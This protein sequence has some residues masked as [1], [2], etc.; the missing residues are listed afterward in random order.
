VVKLLLL[1]CE[2]KGEVVFA[3]GDRAVADHVDLAL[4]AAAMI[5]MRGLLLALLL[6]LP[7]CDALQLSP[8]MP[9]L[10]DI[11]NPVASTAQSLLAMRQA[12]TAHKR[13]F[14]PS[15]KFAVQ[16]GADHPELAPI[17]E[18]LDD[19]LAQLEAQ[20]HYDAELLNNKTAIHTAAASAT[21]QVNATLAV[22]QDE[23]TSAS[24][25]C[26]SKTETASNDKTSHEQ[27]VSHCDS[28]LSYIH[29]MKTALSSLKL[30]GEGEDAVH[31]ACDTPL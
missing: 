17:V 8:I 14:N 10:T 19:M 12:S 13:L 6:A 29:T 2:I 5:H 20:D 23:Y 9:A 27:D 18:A 16:L 26:E 4:A 28:E 7:W 31:G 25:N 21:H 11:F 22:K 15:G 3:H 1:E 24:A 30:T